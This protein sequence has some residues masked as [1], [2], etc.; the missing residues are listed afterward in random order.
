M[1]PFLYFI[2]RQFNITSTRLSVLIVKRLD[3]MVK[4]KNL[5]IVLYGLDRLSA[6]VIFICKWDCICLHLY[7]RW[8]IVR[9]RFVTTIV[10]KEF[11]SSLRN[12]HVWFWS[13]RFL[14]KT[15]VFTYLFTSLC[16]QILLLRDLMYLH[17]HLYA[18]KNVLLN[19]SVR[20]YFHNEEQFNSI[21]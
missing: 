16:T 1:S 6:F 5:R 4:I 13:I 21:V 20:K 9:Y 19:I 12:I 15:I 2:L 14:I 10:I 11:L 3:F 7:T 18:C 8:W 17:N